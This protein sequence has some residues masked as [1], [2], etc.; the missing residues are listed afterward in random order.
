MWRQR[1]LHFFEKALVIDIEH[2]C[3]SNIQYAAELI[4]RRSNE[5]FAKDEIEKKFVPY[6]PGYRNLKNT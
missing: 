2:N 6:W 5:T 4:Y 3:R 1:A